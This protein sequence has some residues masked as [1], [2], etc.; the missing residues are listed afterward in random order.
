[1]SSN[2]IVWHSHPVDQRPRVAQ[3]FQKPLVICPMDSLAESLAKTTDIH[4]P[5]LTDF[6]RWVW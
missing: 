1:M 4:A 3:K 2:N 5:W 6:S